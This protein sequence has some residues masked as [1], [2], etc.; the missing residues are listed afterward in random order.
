MA[1]SEYH[2]DAPEVA[3]PWPRFWARFLDIQL[4][5]WP[6]ILLFAAI[7]PDMLSDEAFQGRTGDLLLGAICLPFALAIDAVILSKTGSSIGKGIAGIFLATTD[8]RRVEMGPSFLRNA[9][10]W[11]QGM[12]LGVPILS[13]FT[14]MAAYHDLRD[15]GSTAWDRAT[16]SRVYSTSDSSS[17]TWV[18]AILGIAL[19]TIGNTLSRMSES[20]SL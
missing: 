14:Y 3:A 1:A 4:Y 2:S 8:G 5:S 12:G 20:G 7:F 19:A 10:A 16:D 17:R 15:N 11:V 18:V 13:L 6:V 9:R